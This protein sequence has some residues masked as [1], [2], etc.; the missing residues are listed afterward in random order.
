MS[1]LPPDGAGSEDFINLDDEFDESD[2]FE[3]PLETDQKESREK[4]WRRTGSDAW[5][6]ERGLDQNYNEDFTGAGL[7]LSKRCSEKRLR[8]FEEADL[9]R[10][11]RAGD[12]SAGDQLIRS[13]LWLVRGIAGNQRKYGRAFYGPSFDERVAAGLAGP[14]DA[15]NRYDFSRNTRLSTYARW[16]IMKS[17]GEECQRW[18]YRGMGGQTRAD[19][20][21]FSHSGAAAAEIAAKAHYSLESAERAI[22]RLEMKEVPYE[23][24]HHRAT[25]RAAGL[26]DC[27]GPRQLSRHIFHHRPPRP[28]FSEPPLRDFLS[29]GKWPG[30]SRIVDGLAEDADRRAAGR[31]KEIGR[32]AYALELVEGH[33]ARI[34]ARAEPK[35]YLYRDLTPPDTHKMPK[36]TAERVVARRRK[37]A[38]PSCHPTKIRSWRAAA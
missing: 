27:F 38:G 9:I 36:L 18:R 25:D 33:H 4:V 22:A 7:Y 32:R 2:R 6:G 12:K 26:Y 20:Y 21:L 23:P 17:I 8:G 15:I 37:H 11:Y 10:A 13:L 16:W 1:N 28:E 34:E 35:Q 24:W 14:G 5:E 31:L 30:R 29:A 19:R 3:G